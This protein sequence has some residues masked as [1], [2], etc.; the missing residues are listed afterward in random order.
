[1][2]TILKAKESKHEVGEKSREFSAVVA[3]KKEEE[4]VKKE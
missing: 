3:M 1:M 4:F 2:N